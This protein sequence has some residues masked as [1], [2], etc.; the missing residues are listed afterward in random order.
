MIEQLLQRTEEGFSDLFAEDAE[1]F[2]KGVHE[3][4]VTFRLG[5]HLQR[6]FLDL[7][8]VV[9]CE[10]NRQWDDPKRRQSNDRLIKPD[11]IVHRRLGPN[12]SSANANLLIIEAKKTG[13]WRATFRALNHRLREMTRAGRFNYKLGIC[14]KLSVSPNAAEQQVTWFHDGREVTQTSLFGFRAQVLRSLRE[15]QNV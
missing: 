7:G 13:C 11:L 1:L 5:V 8:Y 6:K 15:G 4:T 9:D 12:E 3:Q 2:R 10:Y 14:W